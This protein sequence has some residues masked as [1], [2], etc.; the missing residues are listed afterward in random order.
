MKDLLNRAK[1]EIWQLRRANE[2]LQAQIAVVDVFAAALGLEK[3][4]VG[5]T[6]DVAWELQQ[7][8]DKIEKEEDKKKP[9]P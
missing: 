5:M 6:I 4:Q 9:T 1:H 8:I 3:G 7:E 2:I